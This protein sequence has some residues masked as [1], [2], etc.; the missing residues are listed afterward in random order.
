MEVFPNILQNDFMVRQV[1]LR[2]GEIYHVFN[3][4]IAGYKIFN[5]RSDYKRFILI[6][7][8]YN[9]SHKKIR[10]SDWLRSENSVSVSSLLLPQ[11]DQ[12]VKFIAYHIMPTHYHIGIKVLEEKSIYHYLNNIG[13]S[14]TRYFNTKVGRK[15][16]LWQSPY[17]AVRVTSDEQL[18][19]LSR[20]IHLNATTAGLVEN[21]EDWEYS[22]YREYI[23]NPKILREIMTEISVK[24]PK[25]YKKFVENNKDYQKKLQ[26]IKKPHR[27]GA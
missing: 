10:L 23:E 15:G 25:R 9:S 8:Y 4:S 26:T 13:N 2:F 18:L 19:H 6:L 27:G 22:S 1:P 3:K 17:K 11:E 7:S 21:P 12:I 16:P 14:Y 24:D 5:N 20:Y